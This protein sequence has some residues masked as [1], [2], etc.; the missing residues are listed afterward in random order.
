MAK[1]KET[2]FQYQKDLD[3]PIYVRLDLSRFTSEVIALFTQ[4][5][6]QELSQKESK[7]VFEKVGKKENGRLLT[8]EE[9]SAVVAKQI[10]LTQGEDCYGEESVVPGCGRRVYRYKSVAIMPYSYQTPYWNMGCFNDFGSKQNTTSARMVIN[11][12]LSYALA[13]LGMAGFWGIPIEEGIILL[14][15]EESKGNV[16]FVDVR[17]QKMIS[18][19]G[20]KNIQASFKIFCLGR[21]LEEEQVVMKT[22]ELLGL[23]FAHNTYLAYDGPSVPIRQILQTL[24]KKA[25]GI[26]C[27]K[28]FF[29]SDSVDSVLS[30]S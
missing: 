30:L 29:T 9:P 11:R 5:R 13:P 3:I 2:Y 14:K 24:S 23:L 7:N 16:V 1:Q 15:K 10:G 28:E 12:F 8:I 17:N 18:V 20:V 4:M 21:R 22:E 25:E 26:S 27:P 6:F 19:N